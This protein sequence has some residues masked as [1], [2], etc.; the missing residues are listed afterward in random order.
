MRPSAFSWRMSLALKPKP[1]SAES[2]TF[3]LPLP[4][5]PMTHVMLLLNGPI[6]TTP[7]YDLKFSSSIVSTTSLGFG[8]GAAGGAVGSVAAALPSCAGI[9]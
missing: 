1:K 8:P 4:L 6:L 3:D 9:C 2:I 5:G 7:K